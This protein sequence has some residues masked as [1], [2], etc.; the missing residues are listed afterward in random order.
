MENQERREA[1]EAKRIEKEF[2]SGC[3]NSADSTISQMVRDGARVIAKRIVG[4]ERKLQAYERAEETLM[5][6]RDTER[7]LKPCPFCG[8]EDV[9]FVSY[10]TGLRYSP[11]CFKCDYTLR[12]F[13][14]QQE[15]VAAWNTRPAV[16][17]GLDVCPEGGVREENDH[18][19]AVC[20]MNVLQRICWP[21][22]PNV[23]NY[24]REFQLDR[25]V[26]V[27]LAKK[28]GLEWM[29]EQIDASLLPLQENDH[30]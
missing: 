19:L 30:A 17:E 9:G 12:T 15:A 22:D 7:E 1:E 6:S 29:A 13:S 23:V 3:D 16:E 24:I 2:W 10:V 20:Q 26:Y 8:G 27:A 14:S 21:K 18:A 25:K 11:G 28:N 4:N 5:E